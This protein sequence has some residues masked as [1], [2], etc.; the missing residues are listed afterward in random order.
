MKGI[1][2]HVFV[3][4]TSAVVEIVTHDTIH[5]RTS[6]IYPHSPSLTYLV[7]ASSTGVLIFLARGVFARPLE[8]RAARVRQIDDLFSARLLPFLLEML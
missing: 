5:E 8:V 1:K 4:H 7:R 3:M 6:Y 2:D